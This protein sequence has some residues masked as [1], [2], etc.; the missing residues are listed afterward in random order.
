MLRY[1]SLE[2]DLF[3]LKGF[4][5]ITYLSHLPNLKG[6]DRYDMLMFLAFAL[7][8]ILEIFA[9]YQMLA[10]SNNKVLGIN[11]SKFWL[12]YLSISILLSV[13]IIT[14]VFVSDNIGKVAIVVGISF[15]ITQFFH[16]IYYIVMFL[17]VK[18]LK[19]EYF[20]NYLIEQKQRETNF[21]NRIESCQNQFIKL[22]S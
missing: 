4:L 8:H 7:I 14:A 6:Y 21:D 18:R 2:N 17:Y 1:Y 20:E 11:S 3:S 12:C 16:W 10:N 22:H 15:A 13:G 5:I 9:V 19:S